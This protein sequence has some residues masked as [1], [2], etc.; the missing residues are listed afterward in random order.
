MGIVMAKWEKTCGR[1]GMRSCW[2][3]GTMRGEFQETTNW[4]GSSAGD[5]A[6]VRSVMWAESSEEVRVYRLSQQQTL[7]NAGSFW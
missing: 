2:L 3:V 7:Q 6:W 5:W 1:V 4:G